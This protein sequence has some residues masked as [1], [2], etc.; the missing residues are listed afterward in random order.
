M[1]KNI[2]INDI[3]RTLV[4]LSYNSLLQWREKNK[5]DISNAKNSGFED[6]IKKNIKNI[7]DSNFIFSMQLDKNIYRK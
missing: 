4:D 6:N 3:S 1:P 2:I 5:I 7:N